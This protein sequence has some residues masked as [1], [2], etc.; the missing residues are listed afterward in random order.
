MKPWSRRTGSGRSLGIEAIH[1]EVTTGSFQSQY[2]LKL[3]TD[4]TVSR[5]AALRFYCHVLL[6]LLPE[7]GLLEVLESL[8]DLFEFH[9]SKGQTLLSPPARVKAPATRGLE[10][11]RPS[12]QAMED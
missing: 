7:D 10:I 3:M 1:A 2:S 5:P 9:Q 8:P 12:F 6:D 4:G 11:E